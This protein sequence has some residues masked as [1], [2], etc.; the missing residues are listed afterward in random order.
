LI[1]GK[2]VGIFL[3]STSSNVTLDPTWLV[4]D[5]VAGLVFQKVNMAS[6]ADHL[7]PTGA[8]GN[9]AMNFYLHTLSMTWPQVYL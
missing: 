7:P 1:L 2:I 5:L 8:K 9:N 4:T 6:E 3:F